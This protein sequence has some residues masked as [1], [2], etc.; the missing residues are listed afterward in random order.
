V[1]R[2]ENGLSGEKVALEAV[3]VFDHFHV[4][5]LFN[6]KLSHLRRELHRAATDKMHKEVLK[7]TRWLLLQNPENLDPRRSERERLEEALRMN[8]PLATE[9]SMKEELR[10]FCKQPAKATAGRVLH[11]GVRRAEASCIK[12]LQQFA[13]TLSMERTEILAYDD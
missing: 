1:A 7:G 5:T 6:E 8:Q 13:A 9:Y 10:Q 2:T 12:G 4:L 3:H 11:D